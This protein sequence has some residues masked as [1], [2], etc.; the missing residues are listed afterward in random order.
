M[1]GRNGEVVRYVRD[2]LLMVWEDLPVRMDGETLRIKFMGRGGKESNGVCSI[3][4]GVCRGSAGPRPGL[5]R[6]I[7]DTSFSHPCAGMVV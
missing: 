1:F 5:V 3:M 2:L 6:R 7:N 4:G